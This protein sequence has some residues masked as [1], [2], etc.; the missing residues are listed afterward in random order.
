[1]TDP[2]DDMV[3]ESQAA[4]EYDTLPQALMRIQSLRSDIAKLTAAIRE[5]ENAD[6]LEFG[7][8]R[9]ETQDAVWAVE[10]IEKAR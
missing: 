9:N 7:G 2:L 3:A 1:M 5:I 4:G 10:E 8:L 6:Y